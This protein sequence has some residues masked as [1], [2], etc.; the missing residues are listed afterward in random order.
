[1][2]AMNSNEMD[3]QSSQKMRCSIVHQIT[4]LIEAG[5]DV[6]LSSFEPPGLTSFLPAQ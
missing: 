1:M 5:T 3:S 2:V 4:V 6:P